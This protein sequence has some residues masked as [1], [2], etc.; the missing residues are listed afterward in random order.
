MKIAEYF[1]YLMNYIEFSNNI[2]MT[3]IYKYNYYI[4][5]DSTIRGKFN[6]KWYDEFEYCEYLID[7][8]KNTKLEESDKN[9]LLRVSIDSIY[10][11][12]LEQDDK[13]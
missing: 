2:Y 4:R 7:K 12:S 3:D 11:F 6:K 5:S 13:N 10:N 8:Y 1:K 9:M